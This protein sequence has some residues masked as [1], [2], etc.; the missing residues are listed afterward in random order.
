MQQPLRETCGLFITVQMHHAWCRVQPF[1][2]PWKMLMGFSSCRPDVMLSF[3]EG[4][5]HLSTICSCL[6][7]QLHDFLPRQWHL[8][9]T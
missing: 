3:A 7:D 1:K 6:Y 2:M 8:T 9:I 4:A 5:A